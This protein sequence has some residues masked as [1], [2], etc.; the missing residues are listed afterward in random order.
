MKLTHFE[1]VVIAATRTLPEA[2]VTT[3]PNVIGYRTPCGKFL[4][5][6][7]DNDITIGKLNAWG[8]PIEQETFRFPYTNLDELVKYVQEFKRQ[9]MESVL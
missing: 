5:A 7:T 8:S 4:V 1:Q 6:I 3:N 9:Y 2:L